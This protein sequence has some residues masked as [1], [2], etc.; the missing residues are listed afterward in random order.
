MV[1]ET[2]D[3]RRARRTRIY[4]IN[5]RQSAYHRD[6]VARAKQGQAG[7]FARFLREVDEQFPGLTEADREKKAR[8]AYQNHMERLSMAAVRAR[9]NSA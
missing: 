2:T 5:G 8:W 4:R 7:L 6:T 1:M 3:E 9:R